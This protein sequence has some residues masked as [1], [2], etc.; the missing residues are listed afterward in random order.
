MVIGFGSIFKKHEWIT[1]FML[2]LCCL[3]SF[4]SW[5]RMSFFVL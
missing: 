2:V 5:A 4:D 1:A 3:L